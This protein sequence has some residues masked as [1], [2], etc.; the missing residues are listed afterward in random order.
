M[1]GLFSQVSS[2]GIPQYAPMNDE[3]VAEPLVTGI[4]SAFL[5]RHSQ[6]GGLLESLQASAGASYMASIISF[7]IITIL[8]F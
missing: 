4:S 6:D 1:F 5:A 3:E 8:I 2:D 7:V